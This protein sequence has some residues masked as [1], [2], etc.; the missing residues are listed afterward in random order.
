MLINLL[1]F[2]SSSLLEASL[3]A[4]DRTAPLSPFLDETLSLSLSSQQVLI[5]ARL[6]LAQLHQ[7]PKWLVAEA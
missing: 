4:L 6:P 3:L 1:L 2:Q 5:L 7:Y